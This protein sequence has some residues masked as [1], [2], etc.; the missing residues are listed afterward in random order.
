MKH[1]HRGHCQA[2]GGVQAITPR[3]VAKHGY[4]VKGFHFFNGVC[5]GSDREPLQYAKDLSEDIV[6]EMKRHESVNMQIAYQFR[7]LQS[8][9]EKV[10]SGRYKTTAYIRHQ[11]EIMIP[12][13]QSD[14]HQQRA[15]R[16]KVVNMLET[17]ASHAKFHANMIQRLIDTIH[18]TELIPTEHDT[19]VQV[20]AGTEFVFDAST[21][22]VTRLVSSMSGRLMNCSATNAEG[23]QRRFSLRQVRAILKGQAG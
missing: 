1:T 8:Y 11:V 16:I 17:E 5:Q 9:P 18:G 15:G 23:T 13:D 22:T 12:W 6:K 19:I 10:G 21:W 3:G 14:E 20:K 7:T 2:C 4:K